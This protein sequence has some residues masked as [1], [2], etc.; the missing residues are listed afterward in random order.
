VAWRPWF[1][2]IKVSRGPR[3]VASRGETFIT[4]NQGRDTVSGRDMYYYHHGNL[5]ITAIYYHHD[6]KSQEE[7]AI[8]GRWPRGERLS[9][10]L[11]VPGLVGSTG[12][13]WE[14]YHESRRCSRDTYPESY[15]TKYTS[16]RRSTR[17]RQGL[18]ERHLLA[19]WR[20][21]S[22][23]TPPR[24]VASRGETFILVYTDALPV[25]FQS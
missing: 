6:C 24:S 1:A 5:T 7:I 19:K 16:I 13:L 20:S 23:V 21:R 25:L 17:E 8:Q 15:I 14:G 10:P 4:I 2:F 12:P 18:R 22:F 3:S 11:I 9:L